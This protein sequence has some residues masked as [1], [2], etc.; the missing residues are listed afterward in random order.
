MGASPRTARKAGSQAGPDPTQNVPTTVAPR[1][2]GPPHH[3]LPRP[4]T[5]CTCSWPH[6]RGSVLKAT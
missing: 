5:G 4:G 2:L 3:L 6:A 1:G